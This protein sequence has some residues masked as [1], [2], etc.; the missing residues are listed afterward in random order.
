M[1]VA[2]VSRS[3]IF[4][5]TKSGT[6]VEVPIS[7]VEFQ[8]ENLVIDPSFSD[9]NDEYVQS[10]LNYL[11]SVGSL[12]PKEVEPPEIPAMTITSATRGS[13]GNDVHFDVAYDPPNGKSYSVTA[14]KLNTY[15]GLTLHNVEEALL[16][17]PGL[18]Y[19]KECVTTAKLPVDLVATKVGGDGTLTL[20]DADGKKAL[21]VATRGATDDDKRVT[22]TVKA[23]SVTSTFSITASWTK[24]VTVDGTKTAAEQ[25]VTLNGGSGGG[26]GLAYV[27]SFT[28]PKDANLALPRAGSF[29]LGG[30]ADAARAGLTILA[31]ASAS[32]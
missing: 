16:D 31:K 27:A 19:V 13:T 14:T 11:A 6:W 17:K 8:G 22:V 30:G 7:V 24:E 23:D 25:L 28:A 9:A 5:F 15:Q 21:V 1:A 12:W 20:L 2:A 26:T 4:V 29:D 18:V 10:W 3:P 32:T